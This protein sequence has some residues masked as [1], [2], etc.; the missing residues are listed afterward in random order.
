MNAISGKVFR[1]IESRSV[2]KFYF[3]R[4]LVDQ[5]TSRTVYMTTLSC[6]WYIWHCNPRSQKV[7]FVG[8]CW[9][10]K[11]K[12]KNPN[13]VNLIF[14]VIIK[15]KERCYLE[16]SEW[17]LLLITNRVIS[18]RVPFPRANKEIY[19]LNNRILATFI[20]FII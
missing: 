7:G 13:Q 14:K 12:L 17:D 8:V 19:L 1:Y 4:L 20:Q 9:N 2:S 11:N 16:V 5:F 15:G 6:F 18:K 3:I 10:L